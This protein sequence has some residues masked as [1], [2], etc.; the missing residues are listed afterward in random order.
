[1]FDESEAV[2]RL[3]DWLAPNSVHAQREPAT[4]T[5]KVKVRR[6]DGSLVLER[7]YPIGLPVDE[8]DLRTHANNLR[9]AAGLPDLPAPEAGRG[10]LGSR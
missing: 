3:R 1:M 5:L 4:D 9:E 7:A 2:A 10:F 8:V 6:P